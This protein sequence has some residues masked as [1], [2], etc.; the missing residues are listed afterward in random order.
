MWLTVTTAHP[1]GVGNAD[2]PAGLVSVATRA[3]LLGRAVV[4]RWHPVLGGRVLQTAA[5]SV[6]LLPG[7]ALAHAS[8]MLG[9]EKWPEPLPSRGVTAFI[10]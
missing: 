9:N 6:G 1:E 4:A 5:L 10:Y 8:S 3:V 2:Y 7:L